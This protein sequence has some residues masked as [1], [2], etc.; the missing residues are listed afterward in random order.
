MEPFGQTLLFTGIIPALILLFIGLKGYEGFYR[1]KT[2]FITFILGMVL[3]GIAVVVRM[4]VNPPLFLI[5]YLILLAVFEQLFKTMFLNIKRFQKKK[6]T[7]IY[8]LS[9][10]LGFGSSFTPFLLIVG[11]RISDDLFFLSLL[12]FGSMGFIFFHAATSAYI[13]YGIY[14]EKLTKHLAYAILLQIPFNIF[15]DAARYT[16]SPY[17]LYFQVILVVY[18]LILFVYVL[19]KTIPKILRHDIK[20]RRSKK[21]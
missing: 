14:Q 2:I 21:T 12:A 11:S 17:F 6:E 5:T 8:G 4:M 19:K 9:L 18:G 20:R 7:T 3:G 1:E 13:G 15:T 10:G 16:S